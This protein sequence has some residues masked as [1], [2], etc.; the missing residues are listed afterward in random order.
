MN[1]LHILLIW[2]PT[3]FQY[4]P[5]R[6]QRVF[7]QT[8]HNWGS[9][10]VLHCQQPPNAHVQLEYLAYGPQWS[11]ITSHVAAV[12][13][14][15]LAVIESFLARSTSTVW[16]WNRSNPVAKRQESIFAD[17]FLSTKTIDGTFWGPIVLVADFLDSSG[18]F[19]LGSQTSVP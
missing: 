16:F 5:I 10:G 19:S 9:P 8:A 14:V 1:E 11:G 4:Q 7:I 6:L 3:R 12:A 2:F 17:L 13:C 15:T 18:C